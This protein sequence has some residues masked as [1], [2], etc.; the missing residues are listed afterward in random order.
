LLLLHGTFV[1]AG[2]A[3]ADA[4]GVESVEEEEEA[5]CETTVQAPKPAVDFTD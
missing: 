4:D 1:E 2:G 5:S 3:L